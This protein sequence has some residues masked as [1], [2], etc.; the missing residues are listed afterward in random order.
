MFDQIWREKIHKAAIK[1]LDGTK[2]NGSRVEILMSWR[3]FHSAVLS[4]FR[5]VFSAVSTAQQ[6][7]LLLLTACWCMTE[8][9]PICKARRDQYTEK[10]APVGEAVMVSLLLV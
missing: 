2:G 4:R 7:P 5:E 6:S 10:K 1:E 9:W 3:I 8:N